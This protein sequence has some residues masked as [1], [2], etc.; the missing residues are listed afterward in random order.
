MVMGE[1]EG[2]DTPQIL[3]GRNHW[4]QIILH[5]TLISIPPDRKHSHR[6]A[7]ATTEF[8]A[9]LLPQSLEFWDYKPAPPHV[10]FIFVI[11][12]KIP[13][14]CAVLPKMTLNSQGQGLPL[15]TCV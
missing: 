7:Q 15:L 2:T 6:T 14:L 5:Q 8:I 9:I 12:V 11:L 1:S 3:A 10:V 4:A 13:S